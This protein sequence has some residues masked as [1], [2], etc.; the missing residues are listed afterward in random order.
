MAEQT[1]RLAVIIDSSGAQKNAENLASAL[2]RMTQ[3]GDKASKS[4]GTVA[5][6]VGDEKEALADLLGQINPIVGALNKLDK[7]QAKLDGFYKKGQL[8]TDEYSQYSS[9]IDKT[10]DKLTG[11][12]TELSKTGMSAKQTAF[13]MR[14]IPAQM[15]DIVV[16]LSTG[17]SPFMV[18]MQQGG[19]LKDMFGGIGPAIK[20]V[21]TYMMGLVNPFTIAAGAVG[22]LGLAYYQGA[23]E[24][25]QFQKSLILT[26][27]QVGKT[28]GQLSDMAATI[29]SATGTTQ[30]NASAVLNQVVSAGNI[31]GD[32]LEKVSAAIVNMSSATGQA[33][34]QL[35]SDFNSIGNDPVAA[36]TKL[37][38]QYHF[39]TLATYN[40]IKALQ[41]EGNQQDA[42]RLATDSYA[43]AMNSR[44]KDIH[45]S[46]GYLETAWD[47]L[48]NAAKH[49]WDNMLSV[50]RQDTLQD[51]LNAA[52]SK[53]GNASAGYT[54]DI[55]GN[56][57]GSTSSANADVNILQS[58]V[59]LQNDL[60]G[61]VSS[62]NQAQ[63]Q[64]I[65]IQQE[66]DRVNQQYLTNAEKRNK[67]IQQQSQFL[68]AGAITAQ[69]YASN[70]NQINQMYKD[71][72][73]P[74]QKAG[75]SYT[76]D[77]GSRLLD[78]IN[79]QTAALTT[80]L[81]ATDKLSSVTQQRVK[82]EQ[83][84]ADL[85]TKSQLT[86]D[87]KSLLANADAIDQAYRQQEA[88]QSQVTTLD[89]YRKMQEQVKQSDQKTNDLLIER[90]KLLDR[91]K[92]AGATGT[93]ATRQDILRSTKSTLPQSVT[94]ITGGLTPK[95]GELSGTWGGMQQQLQQ[96]QQAQKA[97]DQWQQQSLASYQA[98]YQGK[99]NLTT[100][101]EQQIANVKQQY[102][103]QSQAIDTQSQLIQTTA[104]QSTMDS[105]VDITKTGFTEKSGVYK[106]A[107]AADKA[108]AIAQS[109]VAIQAG[110]AQAAN[111]VF[112][113]NLLAMASVAAA[114][115]SIVSNISAVAGVGFQ[116]GGYTGNG[117]VSDIAGVV[118]GKEFVFDAAATK[119]IGV[120]NLEAIRKNGLDATLSRSGFGTGAKNV[121]NSTATT[122]QTQHVTQQIS[123]N[124]NPSDTT[125]QLVQQ[126]AK[127]GA[128]Q[129]YNMVAGDLAAGKG[130]VHKSLTTGYTAARRTG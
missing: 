114:T 69:Q 73:Q 77:A 56:V 16:G 111:N 71:P 61:A 13:A 130:Q 40:Q 107:F 86:T 75:K 43:D 125:I 65:K 34:D 99:S 2:G 110:I 24:Q 27:N 95:N 20:G 91:A 112:P 129:G 82:F 6:S 42:A 68:K 117:G 1:S 93:D 3:A 104:I 80:Q 96:L 28:A 15:T 14:M 127:Q 78:Q 46:L 70:V 41:D 106:V 60:T 5:M 72:A 4:A 79:Q 109:M 122:N 120:S 84:I 97:L 100:E 44:A 108:Y 90:L 47:S 32:S 115:A 89:D 64:S 66:A 38:D 8:P 17:Q 88:I 94:S 67:A 76:E 49:A 9:I 54:R 113:A 126:A 85:K 7:Q 118:H 63:Q 33:T 48:G 36:I 39:L 51:K 26:G 103:Q 87:Q 10:R 81:Q 22:L 121:S 50:G 123:I 62:A 124:G 58:A 25:E 116:S 57:N 128:Q 29:S 102:T 45:E 92:A 83:Q 31:A 74:K 105:I 11:F 19:Q 52:Q 35:V 55:W 12:S 53:V 37:N 30:G 119:N 98:Y 23:N 21:G 18:M 59:N 101:Y